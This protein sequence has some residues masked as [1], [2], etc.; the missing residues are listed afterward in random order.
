[1]VSVDDKIKRSAMNEVGSACD[2]LRRMEVAILWAT[3]LGCIGK[4]P[5]Y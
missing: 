4:D 2:E 1:M 5:T 3:V